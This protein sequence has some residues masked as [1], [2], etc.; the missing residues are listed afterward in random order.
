MASPYQQRLKGW[1]LAS[2]TVN[3]GRFNSVK[4]ELGSEFWLDECTHEKMLAILN[5][6]IADA[7][8]AM[9]LVERHD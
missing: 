9:G 4:L 6:R 2:R 1:A 3:L 8:K 7:V 5:A